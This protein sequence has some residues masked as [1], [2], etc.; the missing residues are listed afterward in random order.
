[1]NILL[2]GSGGR[3]HA[4]ARELVKSALLTTLFIAPGNPGTAELGINVPISETSIGELVEFSKRNQIDLTIVGP[5]APLVLGIVDEFETN[6]LKIIGPNKLAAQLEGSKKWAKEKMER[7]GIPTADFKTFSNADDAKAYIVSKNSYPIVIK[8][9]GLA[10]GKGVVIAETELEAFTAVDDSMIHSKFAEAGT[11]IV[12]E[13]F[14]SGEETSIFAFTDGKTIVPM[15]PAQDHKRIFDN[16]KGPNTGGMGAYSPAPVVTPDVYD[17][18][19]DRIF[20]PLIDGFNRDGIDYKGIV[21]AGLMIS[22]GEP[23]TIEF[24]ARFGDPETQV[25]LPRLKTD[26]LT[27]F[28]AIAT[29]TLDQLSLEWDDTSTVCVVMASAG[30][31]ESSQKGTIINGLSR[32]TPAD[33]WIIHAGTAESPTHEI[34]TNGGRVLG[35]VAQGP[36]LQGAIKN[37]YAGV[38]QIQFDGMQFRRDIGAKGLNHHKTY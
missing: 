17:K 21:F 12:I 14:L 38:N 7:Y 1:M 8:A 26:L 16:D 13:E 18:V 27:V 6:G 35:V 33:R 24:N 29:Q 20:K 4:I 28:W 10:A 2:I 37:A 3:E 22:N 36:T 23:I 30:Y 5:E 32:T 9:D 11:T 19:I 15:V 31:P 34:V 25:V